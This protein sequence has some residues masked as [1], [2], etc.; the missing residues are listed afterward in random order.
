MKSMRPMDFV[1]LEVSIIKL[2]KNHYRR[3]QDLL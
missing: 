3:V 2:Y 1:Q